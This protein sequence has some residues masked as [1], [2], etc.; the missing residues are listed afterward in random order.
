MTEKARKVLIVE[1]NK[2][3]I[4]TL[5]ELHRSTALVSAQ[6]LSEGSLLVLLCTDLPYG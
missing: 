5:V 1:A 4:V 3:F 6:N 2:G